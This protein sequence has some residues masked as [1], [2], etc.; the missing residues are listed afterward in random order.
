MK[1]WQ[2]QSFVLGN[3]W[4]G[5]N[6]RFFVLHFRYITLRVKIAILFTSFMYISEEKRVL[7]I[8]IVHIILSPLFHSWISLGRGSANYENYKWIDGVSF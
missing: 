1:E 7:V 6:D 4:A 8:L 3:R 5:A 2:N